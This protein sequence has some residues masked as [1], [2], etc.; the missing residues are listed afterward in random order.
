MYLHT[1]TCEVVSPHF[2]HIGLGFC[3]L[4]FAIFFYKHK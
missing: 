2:D 1:R 3:F 4:G